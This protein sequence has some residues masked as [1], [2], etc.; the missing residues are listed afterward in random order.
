MKSKHLTR[1]A[2]L[3]LGF[4]LGAAAAYAQVNPVSG[5]VTD[6]GGNP[7]A[8]AFVIAEGTNA[9]TTTDADGNF[10]LPVPAKATSLLIQMMGMEDQRISLQGGRSRYE[11]QMSES[12]NFLDE[13]VAIGYGTIIRKE[14]SSSVSSVNSEQLVERASAFNVTQA[15]AGKVAGYTVYNI[16]GIPGGNNTV[17]VRG[18]GSINASS[19]PLYVVDG[20][21]DVNINMINP[22]DIESIDVLK[23]AAA[24]AMYGAKGANGVI[25]VTTKTGK[26]GEGTV[27][28][29]GSVG[30]SMLTRTY[31]EMTAQDYL[32]AIREAYAY[33]GQVFEPYFKEPYEKLF[34]YKK[35]P[36]GT[37]A[38]DEAGLLIPTPKYQT[39]WMDEYYQKGI[40]HEHNVS[41]SK[42]NERN[43]VYASFGYKKAGGIIRNTDARRLN[44]SLNFTSKINKWLDVRFGG[45]FSARNQLRNDMMAGGNELFLNLIFD[46][47]APF[48][49]YQ[50]PDGTYGQQGDHLTMSSSYDYNTFIDKYTLRQKEQIVVLDAALDFHILEGL[51]L[52]VKGDMQTKF[53]SFG[54]GGPGGISGATVSDNGRASFTNSDS[55]RWSNE[56]YFTYEKAFGKL[57]TTSVLGTSLYYYHSEDSFGGKTNFSDNQYEYYKIQDGTVTLD[58]TSGY[59]KQTMHSVYF[60]TNMA[61]DGKYLLGLTLRADGA[62]NFGA[63][64]KYGFFPSA[65]AGWII[66][67]EPWFETARNTVS[68]LK[69]R[70]SFGSVGNA[71]IPSYRT[72][73]RLN[74]GGNMIF[75]GQ[76]EGAATNSEPGNKDLHWETS[77][78]IDLGFDLSLWKNR[79]NLIAD[80]YQR[81]TK[82][83]L[84][85]KQVPNTTGFGTTWT[86][87]GLLRNRGMEIT[88]NTHPVDRR[89]F[90]WDLDIIYSQNITKAVDI[91][92]DRL[93]NGL[94]LH[95]VLSENGGEWN[96]LWVYK[97]M[98]I[99]QLDEVEEALAYGYKPG[100]VKYADIGG[101]FDEN[102]NPIPDGKL[103]DNDR[104]VVGRIMPRHEFSFVN[105]F[106]FKGFSLMIDIMA[107]TGFWTYN[108]R[109]DTQYLVTDNPH[110][111]ANYAWTPD[112]QNTYIPANRN[113]GAAYP[114]NGRYD[115]YHCYRGDYLR[116]RNIA[117]SYDLKRDLLRNVKF[118]RGASIGV[119]AENVYTLTGIPALDPE[120]HAWGQIGNV[121]PTYPIP[122]SVSGTLKLTF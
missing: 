109:W 95:P 37:Y 16:S 25:L 10:S 84:Y 24:T 61:W 81:D 110:V 75:N 106:Y 108:G 91:N 119:L 115:D 3:L 111:T 46:N 30:V 23:D 97:N 18:K 72:F 62:S 94:N 4:L 14:L 7:V 22:N 67:E 89:D 112:N 26:S 120:G 39:A 36:D 57:K 51:T 20:V 58:P 104:Y 71:S 54:E 59:D 15:L 118:F 56:D 50:Y 83:L 65:S 121:G 27:T 35:N 103:D 12:Q 74:L 82:G 70:A 21:V 38:V 105:T 53:Y 77:E 101:A 41:F 113:T 28:Y 107:K 40:S 116:I 88:L 55:F 34:D 49:P 102:G 6:A 42:A 69:L 13:A 63:N 44:A 86:N 99:W 2:A 31:Q 9:S 96:T 60:R 17:F 98:G 100:D 19:S 85:Q 117:L 32:D 80:F 52:T 114:M 68:L 47:F 43:S 29:S 5:R 79:V 73:D 33:S 87:L 48:I 93:Y 64:N 92:G 122:M 11:V 78:Q 8:G 66:S 45:N 90:K 1:I 76:I